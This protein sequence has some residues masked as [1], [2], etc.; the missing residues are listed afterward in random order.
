MRQAP[1][2]LE[3]TSQAYLQQQQQQQGQL[4]AQATI[5]HTMQQLLRQEPLLTAAV[6]GRLAAMTACLKVRGRHS[7]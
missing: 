4:L 2:V 6:S 5:S 1:L 3:T 7:G